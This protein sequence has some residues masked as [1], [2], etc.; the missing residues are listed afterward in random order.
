[1]L[2]LLKH[3]FLCDF[4]FNGRKHGYKEELRAKGIPLIDKEDLKIK[5][6]ITSGP[7]AGAVCLAQWTKPDNTKVRI[8]AAGTCI[9][10]SM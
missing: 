2:H 8:K 3:I 9:S 4:Q 7:F 1:M 6:K 5:N 10:V